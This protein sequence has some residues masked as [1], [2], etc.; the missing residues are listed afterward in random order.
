MSF[1]ESIDFIFHVL[2]EGVDFFLS[3]PFSVKITSTLVFDEILFIFCII[4][5]SS[6]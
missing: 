4:S 5:F 3:E 6:P 2:A 1:V